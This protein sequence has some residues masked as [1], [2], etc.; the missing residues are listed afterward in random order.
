[1]LLRGGLVHAL[2]RR[3]RVLVLYNFGQVLPAAR[4][5]LE[6]LIACSQVKALVTSRVA[7]NVRGERCYP[8]APLALPDPAQMDSIDA[9]CHV[10]TVTRKR[11]RR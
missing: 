11:L 1:M 2:R 8:L 7:L 5:V 3:Q 6:L 10:P 9:L 4:A